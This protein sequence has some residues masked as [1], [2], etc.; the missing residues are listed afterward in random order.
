ML[1]LMWVMRS[2]TILILLGG[3]EIFIDVIP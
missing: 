3:I 2:L 1:L